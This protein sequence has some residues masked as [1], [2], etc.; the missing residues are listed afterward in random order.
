MANEPNEEE[1]PLLHAATYTQA[2]KV[3][4]KVLTKEERQTLIKEHE[5]QQQEAAKL[6]EAASKGRIGRWW[7][8]P[9]VRSGPKSRRPWPSWR[10]VW[11]TATSVPRRCTPC[12]RSSTAKAGLAH[13]DRAAVLGILSLVFWSITLI[14]TVKYVF[15]AM[16][17][18]NNGEGGIFALVFADPQIWGH[19][20]RFPP[21]WAAPRSSPIPCLRRPSRS[22][23]QWKAWKHCRCWNRS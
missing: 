21:C 8:R 5:A 16:R 23:R 22:A 11:Y 17:I 19:G 4:H 13:T 12:R 1:Q 2:P 14:T 18:D 6:D 7:S 10:L 3:S 15:I 20:L 9:P